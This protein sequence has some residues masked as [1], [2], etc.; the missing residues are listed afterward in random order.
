M[1][2][3]FLKCQD[4]FPLLVKKTTIKEQMYGLNLDHCFYLVPAS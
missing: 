1:S 4:H 3:N 2:T